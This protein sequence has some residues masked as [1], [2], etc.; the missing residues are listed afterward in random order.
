MTKIAEE[1]KSLAAGLG[2]YDKKI[3]GISEV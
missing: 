3:E 1:I 2:S